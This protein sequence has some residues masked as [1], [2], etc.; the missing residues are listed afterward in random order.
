MYFTVSFKGHFESLFAFPGPVG[1][2]KKERSSHMCSFIE[3]GDD[4]SC[5]LDAG[6]YNELMIPV[7]AYLRI[8]H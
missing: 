5:W 8:R 7:L 1:P 3:L 4:Y 6:R 2:V